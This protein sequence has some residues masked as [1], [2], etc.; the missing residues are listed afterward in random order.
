MTAREYIINTIENDINSNMIAVRVFWI[1]P[2]K[3]INQ[4]KGF[5]EDYQEAV[6][7]ERYLNNI[8]SKNEF[9]YLTTFA[10][11]AVNNS[12]SYKISELLNHVCKEFR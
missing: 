9:P 2:F 4:R 6:E 8:Y 11:S 5:F 12:H 7:F 3:E 10:G 1:G